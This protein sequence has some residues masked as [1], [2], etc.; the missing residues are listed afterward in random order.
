ME[1]WNRDAGLKPD[2]RL[3]R[4]A[5]AFARERS[6]DHWVVAMAMRPDGVTQKQ[7]IAV[8]GKPHRNKLRELAND[9]RVKVVQLPDVGKVKRLRILKK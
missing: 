2:N 6:K 3:L 9:N 7:V 4:E 8:F 1:R 5:A